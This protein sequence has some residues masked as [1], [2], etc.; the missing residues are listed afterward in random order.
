MGR[1][2][3]SQVGDTDGGDVNLTPM[4]DVVFILLIFFIVVAQFIKPTGQ[5]PTRPDLENKDLLHPLGVMISITSDS[6]IF[7]D[8]REVE[9]DQVGFILSELRV[10]N[11]QGDVIIQADIDSESGVLVELSKIINDRED[12]GI[13]HISA[14]AG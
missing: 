9:L 13:V 1:N 14:K 4:L 8:R 5:D 10:D 7:I 12:I 11:P 2:R 6:K 3:S